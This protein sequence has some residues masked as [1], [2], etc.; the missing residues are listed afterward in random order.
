MTANRA[1][2]TRNTGVAFASSVAALVV[3]GALGV[4]GV[5]TLADSTAGRLADGQKVAPPSQRLPYTSTALIGVADLDGRLTSVAVAV[6][7]SDGVGGTIIVLSAS[8]DSA[9]GNGESLLPL[10]AALQVSG[11]D[12]FRAAAERAAGMSFDVIEI[13]DESRFAQLINPLGDLPTVFPIELFDSDTGE[14]WPAGSTVMSS[15]SAARALTAHND[16]IED[17]Y[18]DP[19]RA[20]V[21]EAIADRVGAGIGSVE[22]VESDLDLPPIGTLDE[23][24]DRLFGGPVE[25]RPLRF[26]VVDDEQIDALLPVELA[27]AFGPDSVPS[28]VVHDRAETIMAFG[29]LAPATRRARRRADLPGDQRI[30]RRRPGRIRRE[31]L[32]RSEVRAQPVAVCEVEHLV[33][34]RLA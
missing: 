19:G 27:N 16:E 34:R 7:E 20:A 23:F 18:F 28:V 26:R 17:W 29:S 13:V 10:N 5:S 3:V 22:P 15:A 2:R 24:L 11:A 14:R 21:W 8:A 12:A 4:V 9:A 31:P 32:G 30:H 6:L 1:R 25:A 33:G